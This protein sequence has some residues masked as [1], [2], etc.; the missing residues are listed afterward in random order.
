[1]LGILASIII[2]IIISIII[3]L[4]IN[5]FIDFDYTCRICGSRH[6]EES[7]RKLL[8]EKCKHFGTRWEKQD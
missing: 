7:L 1:M 3:L 8:T 5:E 2:G 6:Y 4:L